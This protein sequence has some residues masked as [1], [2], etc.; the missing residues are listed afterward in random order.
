MS[1][2]MANRHKIT[3]ASPVHPSAVSRDK[4]DQ[5][6]TKTLAHSEW[7]RRTLALEGRARLDLNTDEQRHDREIG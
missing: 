7:S 6:V 4:T 3:S 1:P 2:Y 5:G